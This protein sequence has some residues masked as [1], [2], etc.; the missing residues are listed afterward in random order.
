VGSSIKAQFLKQLIWDENPKNKYL[1][2]LTY[3]FFK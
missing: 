3:L 1:K 2:T